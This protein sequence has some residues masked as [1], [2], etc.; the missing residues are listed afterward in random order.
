MN[1]PVIPKASQFIIIILAIVLTGIAIMLGRNVASSVDPAQLEKIVIRMLSDTP[2]TGVLAVIVGMLFSLLSGT[3]YALFS[4]LGDMLSSAASFLSSHRQLFTQAVNNFVNHLSTQSRTIYDTF[5]R[6]LYIIAIIISPFVYFAY[7]YLVY[8]VI[9]WYRSGKFKKWYQKDKDAIAPDLIGA[10][11]AV[12]GIVIAVPLLLANDIPSW[13][14]PIPFYLRV[15]TSILA[16]VTSLEF[17]NQYAQNKG[18]KSHVLWSPIQSTPFFLLGWT[19]FVGFI[20]VVI[21][22]WNK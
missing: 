15:F 3:F 9:Y 20:F 7:Y 1:R 10:A 14:G 6:V 8:P 16:T 21:A 11:L 17:L 13:M 19:I 5:K 4:R 2:I 12:S 18:A 22:F